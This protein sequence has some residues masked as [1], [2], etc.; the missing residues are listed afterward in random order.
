[1]SIF[2]NEIQEQVMHAYSSLILKPPTIH[3]LMLWSFTVCI[4]LGNDARCMAQ[5]FMKN[6]LLLVRSESQ[7]M[8][9]S[10]P[11]ASI[12]PFSDNTGKKAWKL[13]SLVH[14][15]YAISRP[16]LP[17]RRP[18]H[19]CPALAQLEPYSF[20]STWENVAWNPAA[21]WLQAILHHAVFQESWL[22]N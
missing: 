20:Q 10:S 18:I 11:R 5:L 7:G 15:L 22:Q 1:M 12:K 21:H 9:P 6:Y 19:R 3:V 8:S 17:P 16:N 14:A 2:W 13:L 4:N